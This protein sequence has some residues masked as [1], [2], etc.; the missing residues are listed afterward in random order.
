V[1][2]PD[3]AAAQAHPSS[4]IRQS[5]EILAQAETLTQ[6]EAAAHGR[7]APDEQHSSPRQ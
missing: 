5:R 7:S 4:L 1:H 2:A 6:G 3:G